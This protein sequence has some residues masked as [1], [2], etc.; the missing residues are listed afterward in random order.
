MAHLLL[1][2]A[3]NVRAHALRLIQLV[4]L[5]RLSHHMTGHDWEDLLDGSAAGAPSW[6]A[7]PP[8]LLAQRYCSARVPPEIQARLAAVCPWSLQRAARGY[9]LSE[10]S[11]SNLRIPAFPGIEWSR[12]P[13]EGLRFAKSRLLPSRAA[14][15]GLAAAQIEQPQLA[16]IN[17]YGRS[18]LSRILRW[19]VGR[20]PRVQTL[21]CMRAALEE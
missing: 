3:G 5:G 8:L 19:A 4:D 17:W 1:H 12:S 15:D 13:V 20:P 21:C 10:V 11:W 6:W 14:L 9:T 2:A 7:Y 18:H 16:T